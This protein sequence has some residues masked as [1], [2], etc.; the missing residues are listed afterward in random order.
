M[1]RGILIVEDLDSDFELMQRG[2]R[3]LQEPP[4]IRRTS[5]VQETIS[6]L[7]GT[8]NDEKPQLIVLDLR[9]TDGDGHELLAKFR[10]HPE[11][12]A[13][14]VLVW[15]AWSDPLAGENCRAQ[16]ARGYYRKVAETK[17]ARETVANITS[18]WTSLL[19]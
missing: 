2:F 4:L 16:G 17:A 6:L 9:L 3:R 7:D 1:K 13:I 18:H 8:Q 10:E 14:P 5:S 12:N 19:S 11:W 15:S